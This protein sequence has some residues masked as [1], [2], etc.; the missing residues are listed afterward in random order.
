MMLKG[1]V[2]VV[3]AAGSGI[4]KAGALAMAKEGAIVIASDRLGERAEATAREIKAGNGQGVA[5]AADVSDDDAVRRLVEIA[6]VDHGRIDIL[7]NHAGIQIAGNL[8][9]VTARQLDDS[10]RVNLRAQ[11]V[12]SQAAVPH[13]KRQGKGVILNT[14]SNAG[15]FV[16]NDMLAYPTRSTTRPRLPEKSAARPPVSIQA[17]QPACGICYHSF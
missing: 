8:E 6:V 1:R 3:T 7:H 12:A 2:A 15:V 5:V 17:C 13:M 9:G 16:D 14:A 11:F 10:Y 4:G